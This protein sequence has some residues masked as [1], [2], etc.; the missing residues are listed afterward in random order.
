MVFLASG[1]APKITN[2]DICS[3][4]FD[5]PTYDVNKPIFI[6]ANN[7][8]RSISNLQARKIIRQLIRGLHKAGVK[9]GDCVLVHSFND[10]YY[11]ILF[12]AIVGAGAVFAGSNPGY[13]PLELRHHVNITQ[14]TFL[15]SEPEL[16]EPL[17]RA[18]KDTGIS[19]SQVRVFN[20]QS[21]QT[22][23]QGFTSWTDLMQHG[24]EDWVRFDDFDTCANTTAA[25]LTSSGTTGLPKATITTHRNLIAQH[26]L[27]YGPTMYKKSY[28][29][30]N[31]YATPMFHAAIAPRCHT[32]TLK[33]GERAY[34]MRRFDLESYLANID[35]FKVTEFYVVSAMA[36]AIAMSPLIKKYSIKSIRH[37]L[38]GAAPLSKE[39][40]A[41]IR[42]YLGEGA[43]FAQ[44]WGM[45]ETTCILT[46]FPWPEDDDTGSVGRVIPGMDLKLI[47]DEG[48]DITGYDVVGEMCA[49]GPTVIKGYFNNPQ[50]NKESFD[51]DGFYHTGDMMYCDSKTKLW[52]IVDRKKE[53]IKVR[54]FQVAPPE[55]E[56]VLLTH[57][58]IVDAAVIG[59][60]A[61]SE[62]DGEA[63]RAYVVRRPGVAPAN[64]TEQHVYDWVAERLA[65]YKRLDGG[66]RFTDV[67]PKNASGKILKRILRE[68]AKKEKA[69]PRL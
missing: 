14:A 68:E 44:V 50:A 12:L 58:D 38:A 53:L 27:C 2:K 54:G 20:T 40:Q 42:P 25:R 49:R 15:I 36:V 35:K 16:L 18:A 24:E 10:I 37:G 60:P 55:I 34:V 64:L 13:T 28:E 30:V 66:V 19:Q 29:P 63:P 52:Y 11:P 57:P 65:K 21:S 6:D 22:V 33:L 46:Q 59:I 67:I 4:I 31:L 45:T 48:K 69:T 51:A 7:T 62:L 43:P 23:P 17:M 9:R 5:E 8:S 41:A 39:T 1:P 32:T 47:D 26:E 61:A 3:W 56:G